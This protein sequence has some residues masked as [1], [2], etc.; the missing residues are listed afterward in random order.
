MFL[1]SVGLTLIGAGFLLRCL[2]LLLAR[3]AEARYPREI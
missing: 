2:T 3:R 1:I